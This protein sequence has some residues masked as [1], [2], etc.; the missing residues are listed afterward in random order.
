MGKLFFDKAI[1]KDF[2]KGLAALKHEAEQAPDRP[3]CARES[4]SDSRSPAD[5]RAARRHLP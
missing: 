1:G 4:L 3:H 5:R 2:D